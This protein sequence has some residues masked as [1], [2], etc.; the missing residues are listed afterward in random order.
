[1]AGALDVLDFLLQNGMKK[2]LTFKGVLRRNHEMILNSR[3]DKR[4]QPGAAK[5]HQRPE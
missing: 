4:R 2:S 1:M 3:I 5:N